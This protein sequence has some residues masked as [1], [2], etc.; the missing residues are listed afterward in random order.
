[1][2]DKKEV[3][4]TGLRANDELTIGNYLG[5]MVP[6]IKFANK[7]TADYQINMFLPD[8]HTITVEVDWPNLQQ[9]IMHCLKQYIAAG[10]DISHPNIFVYRQ[11]YIRAHSE[12]AWI[13]ECFT[14]FGEANRMVEFKDKSKQIGDDRVSAGLFNYPILM[15]ADILLYGARWVPVGEDQ[16][17]HLELTRT[18]AERINSKFGEVFVVPEETNK[19]AEFFG[20]SAPLKIRSLRNPDKKM[21]KSVNDPAGTI[22]LIDKPDESAKKVMS[23]TTDSVGKINFD[24]QKQPGVTN[25]LQMLALLTNKRQDEV[26]AQWVGETSYGD[27]KKAVAEAVSSILASLQQSF[28]KVDD[29]ALQAKL[30]SSEK[31]M[32]EVADA[33]LLQVQ[34]VV[35]LRP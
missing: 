35:G 32:N 8:L 24:W 33:K 28:D 22:L 17:Q 13:L 2:S 26:N 21:S 19:Q 18:L 11:S 10:L 23:A 25:L 12:L 3:V 34:K 14:G 7:N 5:G 9:Q 6:I 29:S 4:L 1:M 20:L 27:L 16:R 31:V 15:A 30:E